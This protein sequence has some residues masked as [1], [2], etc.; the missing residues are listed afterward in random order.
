LRVVFV[1]VFVIVDV[2]VDVIVIV[3]VD[4]FFGLFNYLAADAVDAAYGGDDPDIVAN[5]YLT[6]G[7]HIAE[8]KSLSP[9]P[10]PEREGRI[11]SLIYKVPLAHGRGVR[12]EAF[13]IYGAA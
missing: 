12:G 9:S 3:D 2:I 1:Y 6:V 11:V 10:S 13:I 7:T 8:E 5:A 4:L